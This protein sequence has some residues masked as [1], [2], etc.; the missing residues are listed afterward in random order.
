MAFIF[1]ED[2]ADFTAPNGVTYAWDG[3]KWV[4]KTFKADESALADYVKATTLRK[5]KS[6]RMMPLRLI[7]NGR[8]K[9]CS[10]QDVRIN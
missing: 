3:T 2:K 5:T 1:P 8:T 7:K 9:L 10:D 6:D 4:T